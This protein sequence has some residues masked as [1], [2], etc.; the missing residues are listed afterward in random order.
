[1]RGLAALLRGGLPVRAALM[2]WHEHAPSEL[3]EPLLRMAHRIRLGATNATALTCLEPCFGSDAETL[4]AALDTCSEVGGNTPRMLE[5]IA[6]IIQSRA[7]LAE[8]GRAAGSGALL[9]GR[10]VAGL[11][12]AFVPLMPLARVAIFDAP[13]LALLTLGVVLAFGGL[14]WISALVPLPPREDGAAAIADVVAAVV[15]GGLSL[16]A[17]LGIAVRQAPGTVAVSMQRAA[18]LVALGLTWPEALDR[19]DDG[20]LE[21]LGAA[22]RMSQTFG[23]PVSEALEAFSVRRREEQARRFEA[24]MKRAPVL[25]VIPLVTCVLPSYVLLGL[26]PFLRTLTLA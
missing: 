18:R 16:Q 15:E 10:M 17:A 24:A 19:L 14:R 11:P 13:G 6:L 21:E 23:L 4:R 2:N 8:A 3:R 25:M 12:L 1:M 9:S 7:A 26:G 5:R 20:G 22:L